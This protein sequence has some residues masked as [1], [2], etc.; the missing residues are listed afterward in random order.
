MNEFL[1]HK[2]SERS[3]QANIYEIHYFYLQSKKHNKKFQFTPLRALS[4][5][6]MTK[7]W[8]LS[9]ELLSDCVSDRY[10]KQNISG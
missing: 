8:S 3:I 6:M 1:L 9:R 7:S 10:V 4:M 2:V 5:S